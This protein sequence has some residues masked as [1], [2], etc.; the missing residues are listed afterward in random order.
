MQI[1]KIPVE[2]LKAAEEEL[3]WMRIPFPRP[4]RFGTDPLNSIYIFLL[5]DSFLLIH[6]Y[7]NLPALKY[8]III[9]YLKKH[10]KCL[11]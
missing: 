11:L 3:L 4:D 5:S 1:E 2:K 10:F 8:V 9:A 7:E 6:S